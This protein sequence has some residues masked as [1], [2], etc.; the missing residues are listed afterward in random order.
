[1]G[2]LLL[3]TLVAIIIGLLVVA[4]ATL[5]FTALASAQT[6]PAGPIRLIVPWPPGGGVDT[7]GRMIAAPL[8]QR[9]GQ[10]IVVDNRAGAGGNVGAGAVA[11]AAPDGYTILFGTPGP[12]ANNKLMYKSL[13][14][15]PEQAFVAVEGA[16]AVRDDAGAD[17]DERLPQSIAERRPLGRER[18]EWIGHS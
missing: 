17:V 10:S 8:S 13:P 12:L 14:F 7:T 4:Y 2:L 3:N 16:R 11:K 6:W 5:A 15:D 1:M 9:L 18:V